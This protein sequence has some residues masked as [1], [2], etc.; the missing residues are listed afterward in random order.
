MF[1]K[2]KNSNEFYAILIN[3]RNADYVTRCIRWAELL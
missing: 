3:I 2:N 1:V